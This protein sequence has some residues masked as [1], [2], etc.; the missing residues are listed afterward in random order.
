MNKVNKVL[1]ERGECYGKFHK[2]AKTHNELL[3]IV[4]QA[5][6]REYSNTSNLNYEQ[7]TALNMICMKIARIV[8]GNPSHLDN[9]VDIAGYATLVANSMTIDDNVEKD[10][11]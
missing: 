8:N 11:D 4:M 7:Q 6:Y 1:E 10:N 3:D 2:V 5:S 9:W